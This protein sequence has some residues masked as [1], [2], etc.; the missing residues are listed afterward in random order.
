MYVLRECREDHSQLAVSLT[1]KHL[2]NELC[3]VQIVKGGVRHG[4]LERRKEGAPGICYSLFIQ[5][6]AMLMKTA[7]AYNHCCLPAVLEQGVH[8]NHRGAQAFHLRF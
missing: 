1:R 8:R 7:V 5:V 2:G 6:I 4:I 3:S